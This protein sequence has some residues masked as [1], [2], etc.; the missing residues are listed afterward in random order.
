MTDL[1]S[2]K[3]ETHQIFRAAGWDQIWAKDIF[4]W[5]NTHPPDIL[6]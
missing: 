4:G 6:V 3:K 2:W 1:I 5:M